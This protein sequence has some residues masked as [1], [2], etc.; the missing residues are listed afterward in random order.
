MLDT[1][2]F[3]FV[4]DSLCGRLQLSPICQALGRCCGCRDPV[5][6]H[7]AGD[8]RLA[9]NFLDNDSLAA[10]SRMGT[11][12]PNESSTPLSTTDPRAGVGHVAIIL[13]LRQHLCLVRP[14]KTRRCPIFVY[15]I[16]VME[17]DEAKHIAGRVPTYRCNNSGSVYSWHAQG[18]ASHFF[19]SYYNV[20]FHTN[21]IR[22]EIMPPPWPSLGPCWPVRVR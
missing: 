12:S 3:F 5:T 2:Y 13:D 8:S 14:V 7:A 22:K 15:L 6:V 18:P 16:A 1:F 11:H 19:S 10:S 9:Y 21:C 20:A 17:C 4:Y